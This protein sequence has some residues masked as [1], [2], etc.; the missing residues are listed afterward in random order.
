MSAIPAGYKQTEVG[1]IPEDWEVK[2]LGET[3]ELD[4]WIYRSASK[5][6][7][8]QWHSCRARSACSD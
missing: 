2:P 1:V 8:T 5:Y 6:V 4:D 3:C 7:K